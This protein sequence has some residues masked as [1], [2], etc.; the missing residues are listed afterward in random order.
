MNS[1]KGHVLLE[2]VEL[3]AD[4]SSSSASLVQQ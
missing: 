3:L 2:R 4:A 1:S